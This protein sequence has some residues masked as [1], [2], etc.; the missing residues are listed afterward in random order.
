MPARNPLFQPF[1][2]GS[3]KLPNR[4]VM[5]PMTRSFAVRGAPTA[6]TAAY[7]K[8][9]AEAEVGLIVTEGTVIDRPVSKTD[10]WVPDFFGEA[11]LAGWRGVVEAVHGAG[12]L[13]APQLWHVGPRPDPIVK[14]WEPVGRIDS[15]SGIRTWDGSRVSPMTEEDIA[16]TIDAFARS[17]AHAAALGF[18]C[19]E[20]HGAHGYLIDDFLW[21]KTNLRTDRWGGPTVG[22]RARFAVEVARRIRDEM[23]P[24]MPLIFRLSQWKGLDFDARVAESP[25]ELGEW[26]MPL[27]EAGVDIFHCSQRRFWEPAFAGSDLNLAGWARKVTGQATITVGSVGLSD[28]FIGGAHSTPV[29]LDELNRRLERGDFDLVAVGR[30]LLADPSWALKVRDGRSAEMLGYD[31]SMRDILF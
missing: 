14:T 20:I 4:V 3:L 12:G 11:A 5:A 28:E 17:A 9:R 21:H 10:P 25:K 27:A 8:R 13:I 31:R 1:Q 7:Y 29:S 6:D 18:D 16:D 26:L 2:I 22:E 24:D 23:P 30:A 15:A 19:I